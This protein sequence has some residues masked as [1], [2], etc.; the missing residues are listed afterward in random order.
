M[1][2]NLTKKYVESFVSEE[3]IKNFLLVVLY[4]MFV[5]Y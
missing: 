3:E 1:S 4:G 2:A 5:K